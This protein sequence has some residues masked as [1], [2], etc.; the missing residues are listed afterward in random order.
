MSSDYS[1]IEAADL[2][3]SGWDRETDVLIVGMGAAGSSAAITAREAGAR[4][5]VLDRASGPG[6]TTASAAVFSGWVVAPVICAATQRRYEAW[7]AGEPGHSWPPQPT[8]AGQLSARA[9]SS[10]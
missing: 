3:D 2:P 6:G 1:V 4:V 5:L 10:S 8:G 7:Q 9:M